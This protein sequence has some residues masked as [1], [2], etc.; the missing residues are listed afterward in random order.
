VDFAC[1]FAVVRVGFAC[2]GKSLPSDLRDF[3]FF[4]EKARRDCS[5][6]VLG[7]VLTGRGRI[8]DRVFLPLSFS[9]VGKEMSCDLK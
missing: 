5:L 2:R 8:S 1:F 4:W 7:V 6:L 9:S 3:F